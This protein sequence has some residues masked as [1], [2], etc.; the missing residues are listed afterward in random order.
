MNAPW[1][2]VGPF[3]LYIFPEPHAAI[4]E[5]PVVP[6]NRVALLVPS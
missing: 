3:G 5:L 4:V 1:V 6:A 2:V